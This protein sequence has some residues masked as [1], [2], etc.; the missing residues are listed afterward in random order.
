MF[1]FKDRN[2]CSTRSYAALQVAHL[3]WIVGPGYS[4]GGYILNVSL[5]ASGTQLG[6][7][8]TGNSHPSPIIR[9]PSPVVCRPSSVVSRPSSVSRHTG[10]DDFELIFRHSRGVPTDSS[11]DFLSLM[12]GPN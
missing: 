5:R 6:L 12:G 10:T 11:V 9:R 7:D 1:T 2:F 8:L 3:D 4:S